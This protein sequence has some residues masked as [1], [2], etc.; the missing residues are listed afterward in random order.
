M[1]LLIKNAR[2]IDASQDFVG[3]V[4]INNGVIDCIA[5]D[6]RKSCETIDA[7][8][9]VLMPSFIDL[10][11]HF[12]EPG[13]TNKEDIMSGSLAAA[14]GGYTAVNL[15]ANTKPVCSTMDTVHYV[16]KKAE[17]INI[18][19]VHQCISVTKNLEGKD[20]SHLDDITYPVKFISDDGKG[21][22]D[23]DVMLKA[24]LKAKE[25][26]LTVISHAEHEEYVKRNTRL[27]ENFMTMRDIEAA[28]KTGCR[29]HMA[30][31]STKEAMAMVIDAKK[32]G[33]KITCEVT[34]HHIAL[35]GEKS[36]R[37]NPPLREKEDI[38]FLI[39]ALKDGWVDAIATDHA[40]H[41]AEDKVNGAPGISGIE[42]SFPVCY[43]FLVKEGQLTINK[44]SELMSKNPALIMGYNKGEIKKG[45]DGD[46]VLVD[47]NTKFK[48]LSSNFISKGKN[49]PFEGME[50]YGIVKATVK[51]GRV[52]YREGTYDYRQAL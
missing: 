18:I 20:I 7:K 43:T 38:E 14:H 10:H 13:F 31:V 17:E 28:K 21:I 4:Y 2:I 22:L 35:T 48:V 8:G 30:H 25:K 45:Y 50:L 6:I 5:P 26:G 47:L 1:E 23:D 52:I 33:Y 32:D 27:S 37:V 3:D 12:R 16:L 46:V 34:P 36:Y 19:D 42:T 24:M 44:L 9:L 11:S 29:L 39:G 15:M 49:T 51:R 41:S 40:P